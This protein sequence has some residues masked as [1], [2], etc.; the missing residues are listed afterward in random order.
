MN[1]LS[2]VFNIS[3][4]EW[5]RVL[6]GWSML[7]LSRF[8]FILGWSVLIATFLTKVGINL[9][10][11]LFL[12][13]AVMVMLGSIF[14][15]HLL[16]KIQR[17]LL[18]SIIVLLAA[19]MLIT[20]IVF[21]Q[22]SSFI[23]FS[24]L[25]IVE[26][27]FL[28]Q[29]NILISLFNEDLFTPLESQR[30]FPIIESAET[31]GAIVGGFILSIFSETIPAYKFILIWA[32]SL[33]LIIPI[34]LFFNTKTLKVPK[35]V[36]VQSTLPRKMTFKESMKKLKRI[37]FLKGIM[38]IVLL[39]WSIMNMVEFQYTKAIQQ[40]VYSMQEETLLSEHTDENVILADELSIKDQSIYYEQE[41]TKKL[42]TLHIIFNAA[43]LIIQLIVASRLIEALGVIPVMLIHPIISMLNLIALT[44]KFNFLTAL[45][46]RGGYEIT[47][48]IFKNSY[49]SSYYAI[50]NQMRDEVK[51]FMQGVVKPMGAILGTVL[52]ILIALNFEGIYQTLMINLILITATI[53]MSFITYRLIRKYTEMSEYN[54]SKKMDM[55]TRLNAIEILAQNGHTH[56][57]PALLKILNRDYE[58]KIIKEN[59]L[60]TLSERQDPAS[61]NAIL[62]IINNSGS[63]L[64]LEAIQ[65][66]QSFSEDNQFMQEPFTAHRIVTTLKSALEK[67]ENK[68]IY[69][70]LIQCFYAFSPK[71]ATN[72]LLN[73]LN[74]KSKNIEDYIRMFKLFKDP[75]LKHYMQN[76]LMSKKTRIRG[77]SIIALWQFKEMRKELTHLLKQ[78]IESP[79][80]KTNLMAVYICGEVKFK[81]GLDFLKKS[82]KSKNKEMQNA[83]LLA[84]GKIGD[85]TVIPLFIHAFE[86]PSHPWHENM[87]LIIKSF[88]K[89][90]KRKITQAMQNHFSQEVANIISKYSSI[91]EINKSSLKKLGKLYQKLNAHHEAHQI[92]LALASHKK[93]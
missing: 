55:P 10:P 49:D 77:A 93:Q 53:T 39:H 73:K 38:I 92:K 71:E 83:A 64:C 51:E 3:E 2:Q 22:K 26:S 9:L 6:V 68:E 15:R 86:N 58:P 82:L 80:E 14:F 34:V 37:P 70:E 76:F 4:K 29:L 44:L 24:L 1:K 27:V 40:E 5:P 81:D 45:F 65:A 43:A 20:S 32:I 59:I 52:I 41:L 42:G 28:A 61:I 19:A 46:T 30:S 66:L 79:K 78:M 13:N 33:L 18:I 72:F 85:E 88:S 91:S 17:E 63:K 50:P 8:G 11:L 31:I 36:N 67:V 75:N 90:Y 21:M 23:F 62:N 25:I 16:R 56:F 47:G 87:N 84:L 60:K 48:L 74:N 7:F 35:L 54:L 69:E 12:I 57:T 89:N